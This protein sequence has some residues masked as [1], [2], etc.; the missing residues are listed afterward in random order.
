MSCSVLD[1]VYL[2]CEPGL[3]TVDLYHLTKETVV[4]SGSGDEIPSRYR[5][6]EVCSFDVPEDGKITINVDD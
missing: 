3:L 6:M 4:W 1:F 2:C 5:R